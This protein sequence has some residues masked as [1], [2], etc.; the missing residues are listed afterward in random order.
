MEAHTKYHR[1]KKGLLT[2]IYTSQK[3]N[4]KRRGHK[5][6]EYTKDELRDWLFSQ[7]LFQELFNN[8]VNSGYK[9]ELKPSVDR[10]DDNIH[11]RLDNIRLTTWEDNDNKQNNKRKKGEV[12]NKVFSPKVVCQYDKENKFIKEYSSLTE[13]YEQT[14]IQRQDIGSVCLGKRK[15]AGGFIWKYKKE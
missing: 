10:I 3:G 9:K 5:E 7:S 2:L 15:T 6:P 11:Y 1:T 8:W 4:S 13:A 12:D 14:Q